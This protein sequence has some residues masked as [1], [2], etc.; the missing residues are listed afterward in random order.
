M[1][2]VIRYGCQLGP[3]VDGSEDGKPDVWQPPT[4]VPGCP[5]RKDVEKAAGGALSHHVSTLLRHGD[6]R[7]RTFST[8]GGWRKFKRYVEDSISKPKVAK[9][10]E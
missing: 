7:N 8:R 10:G 3:W 9:E 4:P 1:W 2:P 5:V 6:G